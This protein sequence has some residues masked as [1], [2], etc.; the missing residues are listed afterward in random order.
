MDSKI[1]IRIT[2]LLLNDYGVLNNRSQI[3]DA[4]DLPFQL[5]LQMER[6]YKNGIIQMYELIRWMLNEWHSKKG[7]D[8]TIDRLKKILSDNGCESASRKLYFTKL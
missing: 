6:Q 4:L 3:Y 2:Q 5:Q 1:I 7:N 8:A